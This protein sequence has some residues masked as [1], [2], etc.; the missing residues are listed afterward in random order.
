MPSSSTYADALAA[1]RPFLRGEEELQPD[2]SLPALAAVLSAAGA[3]ECW[4]KHGT[5][6]AHLLDVHRILRLWSAPDAVAR[7]GLYHSAYS[8]SYVNLAIFEPD[9]GRAHVAGVVGAEAERL[10]HL[11]CVVPRQQLIHDDLLFHYED[12]DLVVDLARSEESLADARGGV[13]EEDE[14]WRRKIQR[15]LPASGITVKHIRTGEDVALSRRVAAAFLLM[16]MADF[17]DQL[18]DWQDRLF[19]NTNGRL[20]FRGNTWTSLWPGTGKPGLWTTS[21]SRMG[22][23][24]S[25]IVREEEIY[26]A[27]RTHTTGQEGDETATRDED[28]ALVIPPVFNGCTKV[29]NADDQKAARDLY[30]EAVCSDEEAMDRHRVEELLRQTVAKNPF[31]GEPRLVLAQVCLN[32]EMYEE[33][34]EQ[35]EEGLKLLLEWGSSWDKRMTWEGWVSWGRAM[36]TKAKE[37]D[38]PHTSFGILSLGL[39]K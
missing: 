30:W 11:F 2:P 17:S 8:N 22:A 13:F 10:V 39:V 37:K 20:E 18:F 6:L 9:V 23:L 29:L 25:L 26:I 24:Y 1:A 7:C 3:G 35:A 28:I 15:L 5:F 19:D 34:Q 38:W 4:H 33:A 21:I 36:L 12:E 27:H 16:T 31:V 32:A 14:P